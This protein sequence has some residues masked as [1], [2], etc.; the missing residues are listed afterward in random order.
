MSNLTNLKEVHVIRFIVKQRQQDLYWAYMKDI[1]VGLEHN[2]N[3]SGTDKFVVLEIRVLCTAVELSYILENI[4]NEIK[5]HGFTTFKEEYI[6]ET[7]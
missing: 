7:N 4:E 1:M 6:H 5:V 3:F 2:C